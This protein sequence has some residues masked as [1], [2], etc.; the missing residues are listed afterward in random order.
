MK[1]NI[2]ETIVNELHKPARKNYRRRKTVVK[3][4][5]DLWQADLV[6]MIPYA[7]MNKGF[8]YILVVIDAFSKYVWVQ[9]VK[10]K[11]GKDVTIAMNHILK[12]VKTF[13]RNLQ[14]DMGKEFFNKDFKSLM[15][16]FNINHYS[17][18]SN[19][20]ASIVERV[21]RTLKNLM[22][23][24]FSLQGNYKWLDILT[25][26][27]SKYN[28]SKHRTIG[29]KPVEVNKNNEKIIL[30]YA[31]TFP[32]TVDPKPPKFK[33]DD[34]VRI[35]KYREAFQKGYTP[36]W[37]NEVFQIKK[38]KLTNPRVYLLK[39]EQNEDIQGG[40]YEDELQKVK[41]PDV[42]LVEKVL[43]RKAD[44]VYVKWLGMDKSHNSWIPKSELLK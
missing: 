37:S 15:N 14:T 10:R 41:Y 38:V 29:L 9:P 6:E 34:F 13:P 7:K 12:Q 32:K 23:K 18:Y 35:S 1:E 5:N 42:Y 27:V 11:N 22:W 24:K 16:K 17:T 31:Y 2:K 26:I 4:L 25:G 21:N 19:L 36:N 39:D 40:F 43:K 8:R 28:N 33:K 44:K 3:G 20:K 30:K